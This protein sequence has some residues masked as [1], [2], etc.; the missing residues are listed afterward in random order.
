MTDSIDTS[1]TGSEISGEVQPTP[2]IYLPLGLGALAALLHG[3]LIFEYLPG[4]Q[5]YKYTFAVEKYLAGRL[6]EE[7]LL[8]FSP[9]YFYLHLF[10]HK[11]STHPTTII[12][13][14]HI[15]LQ[16]ISTILVFKI[17][18]RY[19]GTLLSTLLTLIFLTDLQIIIFNQVFE[20]EPLVLV[21]LLAFIFFALKHDQARHFLS[22]VFLGLGFLTRPNF[23][24][25]FFIAPLHF[26]YLH[27]KLL[28]KTLRSVALFSL[29]V[30]AAVLFLWIRNAGLVGYFSPFVMNPGTA[31]FEGNNPMSRG[32]S[33]IYPYLVDDFA[34]QFSDQP[35]YHHEV[36]RAF[37]RR[38]AEQ[39]LS[40][41]EVNAYWIGKARNFLIENPQRMLQLMRTKLVHIFHSFFWHDLA[42]SYWAERKLRQ[43]LVPSIPFG[44]I[45]AFAL[46]GM[47]LK[48]SQWKEYLLFY[49][50]VLC[51]TVFMLVIY[52]SARQ[53]VPLVPVFLFFAAGAL[54]FALTN[55]RHFALMAIVLLPVGFLLNMQT[56]LMRE[57]NYL[58]YRINASNHFLKLAKQSRNEGKFRQAS[59]QSALA[60][61]AAP[62]LL[63]SRRLSHVP[64]DPD[65]IEAAAIKRMKPQSPSETF[66]YA[67]LLTQTGRYD[68][69]IKI[70]KDLDSAGFQPKRDQYQ[71]S[72]LLF[73][74][75]RA[76]ALKGKTAEALQLLKEAAKRNP[77]DPY[78]LT[79][80]AALSMSEAYRHKLFRYFDDIDANFYL[81]EADLELGQAGKAAECFENV[82]KKLPEYRK[83]KIYL[84]AALGRAGQME[85][86]AEIY[87]QAIRLSPDP[88]FLESEILSIFKS[89]AEKRPHDVFAQYSLGAVLRQ[90]GHFSDALRIQNVALQLDPANQNIKNEIRLLQKIISTEGN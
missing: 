13:W 65:G 4:S 45:S 28:Q 53:R 17:A 77:G 84:A 52:V 48:R 27:G 76:N 79:Y 58:W 37:A 74:M 70:L 68:E 9:L 41:P 66:D 1:V 82:V 54:Q 89:L 8:D 72:E 61:A 39:P 59:T 49:S 90:Y 60:L 36:Y 88:V 15:G 83:A 29:P 47:F 64:F 50:V 42:N 16:A 32:L 75:A 57:E 21:F 25:L 11:I 23:L 38:I 40:V 19:F 55:R 81:G 44:I 87:R 51:Q 71:S 14:I 69:S 31:I 86:A 12:S 2:A 10:V 35:D 3:Y 43:S 67:F 22:G 85:R 30:V 78:V 5:L 62:W 7:R 63:D 34:R 26:Y 18:T 6:P 33:S 24:P 80:L 46:A 73:Y 20:P 56:D